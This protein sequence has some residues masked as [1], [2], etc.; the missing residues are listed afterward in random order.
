MDYI[1]LSAHKTEG[2]PMVTPIEISFKTEKEAKVVRRSYINRGFQVS[3]IGMSGFDIYAFDIYACG[4][5]VF[6]GNFDDP[7]YAYCGR[8]PGHTGSHGNWQI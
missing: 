8:R 3:L 2:K 5:E 6:N 4:H 7:E 1:D